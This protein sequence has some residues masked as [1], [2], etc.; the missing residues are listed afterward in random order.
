[1]FSFKQVSETEIEVYFQGR[2]MK[3]WMFIGKNTDTSNFVP[4]IHKHFKK[5]GSFWVP[6]TG[7]E[8]KPPR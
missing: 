7:E 5:I 6:R 8:S 2:I 3:Q 4:L 1:M